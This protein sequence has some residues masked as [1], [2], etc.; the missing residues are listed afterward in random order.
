MSLAS[1]SSLGWSE[2]VVSLGNV[3]RACLKVKRMLRIYLKREGGRE[4]KGGRE[5]RSELARP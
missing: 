3:M 4:R 5:R 1:S 2:F